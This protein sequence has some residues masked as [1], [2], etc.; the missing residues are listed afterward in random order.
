MDNRIASIISAASR[1]P[2]NADD[3]EVHSCLFNEMAMDAWQK[4]LEIAGQGT[5]ADGSE[6]CLVVIMTRVPKCIRH[7]GVCEKC[8]PRVKEV[9]ASYVTALWSGKVKL[10]KSQII[11]ASASAIIF[12]RER[13]FAKAAIEAVQS[14]RLDDSRE[15]AAGPAESQYFQLMQARQF[16]VE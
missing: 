10:T 2:L 16:E 1:L 13:E 11:Y 4:Y 8:W 9:F 7:N 12:S 14:G 6:A 15:S 5:A 3:I